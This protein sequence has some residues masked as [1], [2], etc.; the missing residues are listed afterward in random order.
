MP[1]N[2]R[3]LESNQKLAAGVVLACVFLTGAEPGKAVHQHTER[4]PS[5]AV[6]YVGSAACALC[7]A[8][9]Y[10]SFSK[11][12]MGRSMSEVNPSL[13]STIPVPISLFDEHLNRHFELYAEDG[14][15]YQTE[16]ETAPDGKEVFRDTHQISWVLGAG[17]NGM[18]AIIRRGSYLFEAPLSYYSS[19]HGWALSP[20]YQ[21]GDYGFSRP[22]LPGCIACHSGRARPALEG[23]GHFLDPPFYQLAVGCENCHG[24]G[25][26]HVLKMKR[27]LF[28][29]ASGTSIVNPAKLTPWL[30]DN[31]CMSCHQIGDA[32]VLQPGKQYKD[33]RP[34]MPLNATLNIVLVP[35]DHQH[36]PPKDDLLEHYLS[37]RLSKCY[38]ESGGHMTCITCHDPH[39]QP[40]GEEM[41][42]YFRK[43][44]LTC[45]TEHNCTAAT[46]VRHETT[47]PDDCVGCHMPKRQVTMISHSVLT[48]HRIV[49]KPDEPFPDVAF[50]MTTPELPDLVEL[51]ATP[52]ARAA[53][54]PLVV[55]QAYRQVMLS[56]PE[57]RP[58]YW[59]LAQ[60][61]QRN[62]PN[63]IFVLEGLADLS[64]QRKDMQGLSSAIRYLNLARIQG[65]ASP[66]DFEELGKLLLASG[67]R[68]EAVTVLRQ[69]IRL[70]PYDPELY[71]LLGKTYVSLDETREACGV[72]AL[73]TKFLPQD[74][75]MRSWT[76]N[77][78]SPKADPPAH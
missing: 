58:R 54:S 36:S 37:M 67:R 28:E 14:S 26:S 21:Y 48:N 25:A 73:A 20:G 63:N 66:S 8:A 71:R 72:F 16:Y 75:E 74:S 18:G 56:H 78:S 46:S 23:N 51:N 11:T 34:G 6:G 62:H 31:I 5:A 30:A 2:H 59:K 38:R 1:S 47:P 42:P 55:L 13:L 65:S 53:P 10:R 19:T 61:L 39:V 24:P 9:I 45:H 57:Y 27:G 49:I 64:L 60:Q 77:C 43:K 76:K 15:L 32:R 50:H 68:A 22:I 12:Y 69:G 52:G 17:A 41:P 44:C 40:A 29:G 35:Y 7:H 33:F 4:P 3:V 70:I